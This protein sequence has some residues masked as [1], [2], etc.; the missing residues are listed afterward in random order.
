MNAE[1][2][3]G[4]LEL[5]P[6]PEGGFFREVYRSSEHI[7]AAHLPERFGGSRCFCTAIYYLLR[8]GE[9]SAFHTVQQDEVWHHYDGSSLTLHTITPD[10]E[11]RRQRIGKANDTN[12]APLTVVPRG[13]L[14]AASVDDPAGFT[15]AGC[16]VAPGFEFADFHM[17]ARAELVARYPQHA[18]LI[19]QYTRG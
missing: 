8:A 9:Y 7:A 13:L 3:I 6:H 12:V 16:T 5:R 4:R 10:G 11:Y 1:D 15:L 2:W 17:P 14:F 18:R 19:E